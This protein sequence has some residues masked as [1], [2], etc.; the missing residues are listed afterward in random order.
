MTYWRG[1]IALKR[2]GIYLKHAS[3]E[4][5]IYKSIKASTNFHESSKTVSDATVYVHVRIVRVQVL[6]PFES[7][8]N[9]TVVRTI[10]E[11]DY[12]LL[13]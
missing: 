12:F 10:F 3:R 9:E 6:T 8:R 7:R 4:V 5:S 11:H 1:L 13:F 2:T